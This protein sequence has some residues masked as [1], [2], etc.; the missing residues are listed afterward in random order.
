MKTSV[1][2]LLSTLRVLNCSSSDEVQ[3]V[4]DDD[5]V[6]GSSE[7]LFHIWSGIYLRDDLADRLLSTVQMVR[8]KSFVV[9]VMQ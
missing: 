9:A 4:R 5:L 6:V 8:L 3:E 1:L 2:I 7:L